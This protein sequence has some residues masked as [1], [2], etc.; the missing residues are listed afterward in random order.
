[1][2]IVV[3]VIPIV[4]VPLMLWGRHIASSKMKERMAALRRMDGASVQLG[5]GRSG[6]SKWCTGTLSLGQSPFGF[7]TVT[8][9]DADGNER[10]VPVGDVH[11]VIDPESGETL[12]QPL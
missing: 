11:F 3:L 8:L 7:A 4:V 5:I 2:L 6:L 1:V 12:Y 9:K 10:G